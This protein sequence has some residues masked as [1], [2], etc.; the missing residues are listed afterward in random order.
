MSQ[1]IIGLGVLS[2]LCFSDAPTV[3]RML[4]SVC[5]PARFYISVCDVCISDKDN[6]IIKLS[7]LF[8]LPTFVFLLPTFVFLLPT[9]EFF[10][11]ILLYGT[12]LLQYQV[13]AVGRTT[14]TVARDET[15]S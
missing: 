5:T 15:T 8:L 4:Q 9:F 6:L 10:F 12:C 13:P 1:S 14:S 11:K 2:K 7:F 3:V